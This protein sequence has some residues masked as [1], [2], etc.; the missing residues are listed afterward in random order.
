MREANARKNM[1]KLPG[2]IVTIETVKTQQGE[3]KVPVSVEKPT[4][5]AATPKKITQKYHR[6]RREK[7]AKKNK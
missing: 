1:F 6:L 3:V 4:N 7:A 2:E 5:T